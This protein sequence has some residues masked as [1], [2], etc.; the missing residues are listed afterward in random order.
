MKRDDF[1]DRMKAYESV[2]TGSKIT[3]PDYLCV[4]IDGKRFSKYTKAFKKPFDDILQTTML[5]TT[6]H[7]VEETSATLGYVQSDEISLFFPPNEAGHDFIFGGKTSKI[8]SVFASIATAFFNSILQREDGQLAYFD[9]RAFAAPTGIE[10]SNVLLWR[11]ADARKNSISALFRWTAGK[12]AMHGL[13]QTQMKRYLLEN[14][15]VDWEDLPVHYK[16]GTFVAPRTVEVNSVN[17]DSVLRTKVEVVQNLGWIGDLP[18]E[19]RV[20]LVNK[21]VKP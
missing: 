6:K 20:A 13:N 17:S 18:L 7:L 5:A 10:A 12:S 11:A 19:V 9:S 21:K 15:S 1:G 3:P 8:N 16:Y 2:Y 14:N 4:R